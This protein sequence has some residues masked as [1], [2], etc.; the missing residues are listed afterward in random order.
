MTD[1]ELSA[2]WTRTREELEAIL[3]SR[4]GDLRAAPYRHLLLA[5][6][7]SERS[8]VLTLRRNQLQKE[9][10]FDSGAAVDCHSNI[11]T[12]SLGRFLVSTG[13]ISDQDAHEALSAS[14]SRGVPLDDIL[15]EKNL[16]APTDLYRALQQSLARKLL[17]PFSWTSGSWSLSFD[18]PYLTSS[19]R[20]K[21]PQL[22]VTGA[23][24]V[25][26]QETIDAAV[27]Q[28][29]NQRLVTGTSPLVNPE[30][31]RLSP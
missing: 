4:E 16:L 25:E 3:A 11:A 18:V 27:A 15:I 30:E 17:E 8:A 12:E 26:P 9:V 28:V 6:S 21:V 20:V 29:E 19:L 14:T 23:A 5:I 2:P 10:V 31:L 13:K 1:S 22:L 24:K 7:L